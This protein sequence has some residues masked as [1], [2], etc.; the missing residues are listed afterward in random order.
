[1][2]RARRDHDADGVL[3]VND[4]YV[5]LPRVALVYLSERQALPTSFA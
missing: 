5:A 3:C 4:I 2:G 1:M